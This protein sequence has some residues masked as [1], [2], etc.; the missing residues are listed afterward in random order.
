MIDHTASGAPPRHLI[1]PA[2]LARLVQAA[3]IAPTAIVLDVGAGTGYGAAVLSRLANSVV[4]LEPDAELAAAATENLVAADVSNVAVLAEPLAAG[5]PAEAPYD[6]I[7][8]E[9]AVDAVPEALLRQLK[10]GGRLVAMVGRGQAA[11]GTVFLRSGDAFGARTL[12]NAGAEP[13]PG[14]ERSA[15]FVF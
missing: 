7:V 2:V 5:F 9:G 11:A 6:A 12:F 10:D 3:Q 1:A 15:G 14:F 4:A 8:V 13:L